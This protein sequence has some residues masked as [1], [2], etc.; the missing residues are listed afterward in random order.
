MRD[1]VS[2]MR[3]RE[4]ERWTEEILGVRALTERLDRLIEALGGEAGTPSAGGASGRAG[5]AHRHGATD[6]FLGNSAF[7]DVAFEALR[8]GDD[9][10]L[11]WYLNN[12]PSAFY[13]AVEEAAGSAEA[14]AQATMIRDNRMEP[15]LDNLAVLAM[16][17]ARYRKPEFLIEVR[18]A[19][20]SIYERAHATG[21][22]RSALRVDVRRS[23]VWEAMIKRVYAI[24]AALLRR[25]FYAEVPPFIRQPVT[26]EHGL[27]RR[28]FWAKHAL[29]MRSRDGGLTRQG[30]CAVAEDYVERREWFY[31]EFGENKDGVISALCQFDF[32]QCVHAIDHIEDYRE[33]YPSFGVFYN[34]RTEPIISLVLRDEAARR[35][36]LPE[37][38]DERLAGIVKHLDTAAAQEFWAFNGW[39]ANSWQ[40]GNIRAMIYLTH[41]NL[42]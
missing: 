40:D 26:W 37:M 34:E 10:G 15:L 25:G 36:L 39:D 41:Q 6:F 4:R 16:V 2:K 18:N 42:V 35:A 7:E 21:F 11:R 9:V 29:V 12:A 32:L 13:D 1:L 22:D 8:A 30:L 38:P 17:C 3:R 14:S 33:A 5:R 23:W 28:S 19:L 24:G 20:Y 31:R 27:W